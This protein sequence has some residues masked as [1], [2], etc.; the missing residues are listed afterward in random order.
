MKPRELGPTGGVILRREALAV[1]YD[2]R[3]IGALLKS[4]QWRHV[5]HGAYIAAEV[6]DDLAP[7]ERHRVRARAV[8]KSAKS[9]VV[10]SH[11]SA[12]LEWG[13]DVWDLDLSEVHVTRL[14]GKAGRREA[15]VAQHRGVVPPELVVTRDGVPVLGAARTIIDVTTQYDVE[16]SLVVANSIL[17]GGH[18]DL[19]SCREQ[20][21]LQDGWA[22]TLTTRLVMNLADARIESVGES[23]S[24]YFFWSRALP[25]VI[26]QFEI[27]D[28]SGR[29]VARVDFAIPELE[30]F[31][32]FDGLVKYDEALTGKPLAQVLREERERERY[33]CRVTGW[34][35]IRI[36]WRDL[37]NPTRL[38]REIRAH[39]AR[40]RRQP[41]A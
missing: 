36:T 40:R 20:A 5:R 2:D 33:I 35:C 31:F 27:R 41:S 39:L 10:L 6:W 24:C 29:V 28:A 14:D 12:A 15:G 25:K 30:T 13:A 17:H 21:A 3:A 4:K 1:G 38:E 16:H 34:T 37:E 23:R 32:E 9:P 18:T 19:A 7:V 26:P 11:V 22:R 8:L